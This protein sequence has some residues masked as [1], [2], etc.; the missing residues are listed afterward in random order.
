VF[1]RRIVRRAPDAGRGPAAYGR[2]TFHYYGSAIE[3]GLRPGAF[4]G[5]TLAGLALAAA[6]ILLFEHRDVGA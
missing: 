3:D 2:G 6:G 5:L 1:S 4:A